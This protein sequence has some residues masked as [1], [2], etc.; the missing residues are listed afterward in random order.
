MENKVRLVGPARDESFALPGKRLLPGAQS[1]P[2]L[3]LLKQPFGELQPFLEIQHAVVHLMQEIEVG[4]GQAGCRHATRQPVG[5]GF[6]DR[7]LHDDHHHYQ[8]EKSTHELRNVTLG[9][10]AGERP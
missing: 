10:V 3:L 1:L 2:L 8:Q 9:G 4:V 6:P 5:Q 7:A